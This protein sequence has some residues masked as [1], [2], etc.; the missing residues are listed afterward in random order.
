M[1]V[2]VLATAIWRKHERCLIRIAG[3]HP[4]DDLFS[5]AGA[6]GIYNFKSAL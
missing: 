5:E 3:S 6:K 1:A 2:N 4:K